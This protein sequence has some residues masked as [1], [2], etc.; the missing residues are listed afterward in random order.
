MF[1]KSKIRHG[2]ADNKAV[3]AAGGNKR[4]VDAV[5]TSRRS[6]DFCGNRGV[7]SLLPDPMTTLGAPYGAPVLSGGLRSYLISY[8]EENSND[9]THIPER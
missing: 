7:V 8:G 3:V 5:L 6:L 9:R 2:Y 4:V 1:F